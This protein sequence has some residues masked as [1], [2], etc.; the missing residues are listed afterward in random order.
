MF[1]FTKK[2]AKIIV[3][4]DEVIKKMKTT[5]T[6]KVNE[7]T[8]YK[9]KNFY[10]PHL[11]TNHNEHAFF[12]AKTDYCTITAYKTKKVLF[13]GKE[14]EREAAMW[15]SIQEDIQNKQHQSYFLESIGSDEVGTGDYFGP[16]VVVSAYLDDTHVKKIQSLTIDDSKKLTDHDIKKVAPHLLNLLPYSLLILRNEK[17]NEVM[18]E[19]DMNLNKLKALLH[20]QA[21][22]K[23]IQKINKNTTII[24][25]QFCSIDY[26]K[27]Y[28]NDSKFTKKINFH[29][30]AETKFASVACASIIARY[31]FLQEMEKL[32]ETLKITLIKGASSKVDRQ[33]KQLVEKYGK[34]ILRRIA[35]LHFKN[36]E[37]IEKLS[38]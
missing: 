4:I 13:Q 10:E 18:N 16:V 15:A 29:T 23:L 12:T 2:F 6:I 21:I 14:A 19:S 22:T 28:I 34:D 17:Y 36:T 33:G 11:T 35:K 20:K 26:F 7:E 25:D 37:K 24:I 38:I 8:L 31:I 9:I 32:S 27:Q 30:K 5:V 3:L 1:Y